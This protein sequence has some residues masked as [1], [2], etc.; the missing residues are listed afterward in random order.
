MNFIIF[1][2]WIFLVRMIASAATHKSKTKTK[3]PAKTNAKP[4]GYMNAGKT[5]EIKASGDSCFN[6]N[7]KI[8]GWV[9]FGIGGKYMKDA[10]L[11]VAWR[12]STK[13]VTIINALG[14]DKHGTPRSTLY[15]VHQIPSIKKDGFTGI[16][17]A[18]CPPEQLQL[19]ITKKTDFIWATSKKA[20][21]GDLDSSA[22]I[23][24]R[25]DDFD[26]FVFDFFPGSNESDDGTGE[27]DDGTGESDEK[28]D[29][30][31]AKESD[32]T[33]AADE[34]EES[35]SK[36][37]SLK[38]TGKKGKS[39]E[40]AKKK[41]KDDE[42]D[43][44]SKAKDDSESKDKDESKSKEETSDETSDS[45]KEEESKGDDEKKSKD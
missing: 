15:Q 6:V 40:K 10:N 31:K 43:N 34:S 23:Y 32:D 17:F 2:S 13:G 26:Q 22:A 14:D 30:S 21:K 36:D 8:K 5:L 12:N 18:F 24:T 38:K 42:S 20:P 39:K 35:D 45:K 7:S 28:D 19:N 44:D 27:S 41:S 11:F 29:K 25:H 9:G 3:I 33:A 37:K 4:T 1:Y 16:R